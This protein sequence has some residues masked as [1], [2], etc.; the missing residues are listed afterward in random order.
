MQGKTAIVDMNENHG[1]DP[2]GFDSYF[3]ESCCGVARV[4]VSVIRVE[5]QCVEAMKHHRAPLNGARGGE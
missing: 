3:F 2:S 5:V 1:G 4:C